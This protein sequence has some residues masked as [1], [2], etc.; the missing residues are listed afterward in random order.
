ML[1]F[2]EGKI[3]GGY[4][5][6][7]FNPFEKYATVKK[8]SAFPNFGMKISSK[9]WMTNLRIDLFWLEAAEKH[10]QYESIGWFTRYMG[11]EP[12]IGVPQNGWFIMESP[13]KMD[14][15]GVSLFSKHPYK[16]PHTSTPFQPGPGTW[17]TRSWSC[18]VFRTFG[19]SLGLSFQKGWE[20]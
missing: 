4:L 19:H 14:D 9:T 2:K 6:D 20:V 15:L 5:V 18:W 8:G 11:V 1:V 3:S 16:Y 17:T 10:Q 13:T 7:A 12:K